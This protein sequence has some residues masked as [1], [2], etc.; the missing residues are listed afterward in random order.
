MNRDWHIAI[1]GAAF[2]VYQCSIEVINKTTHYPWYFGIIVALVGSTIPDFFEPATHW[3]HRGI[4]HS[5]G[6]IIF[7]GVLFT[8]SALI[9]LISQ[10]FPNLVWIYFASCFFLGYGFHLLADSLTPMGLP[11]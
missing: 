6:A 3:G 1:G 7:I 10:P 8:I 2:L 11:S 5:K 4:C 9:V